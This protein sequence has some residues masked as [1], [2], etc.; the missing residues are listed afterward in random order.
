[1]GRVNRVELSGNLT[2]ASELRA[3]KGGS[4][5]A[6]FGI[7]VGRRTADG[8]NAVDYFDCIKFL[9]S[10]PSAASQQFWGGIEKGRHVFIAGH[11]QQDRWEKDGQRRSSVCII[12]D[13]LDTLGRPS[14]DPANYA[15]GQ[16]LPLAAAPR[17]VPAEVYDE[18]I[19][20]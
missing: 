1:M 8:S 18:E 20:F 2:A 19:P 14:I 9:G 4:F 12:V 11:L 16:Q 5:I 13:E 15:K 6:K 17:E 10:N 3:T 7:A